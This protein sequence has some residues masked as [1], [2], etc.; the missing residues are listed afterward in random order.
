MSQTSQQATPQTQLET[1]ERERTQ[2]LQKITELQQEARE[3]QLVLEAFE[4]VEQSRRCFRLVGGVLVEQTVAEV[5]PAV[6]SNCT[7]IE[8]FVNQLNTSLQTKNADIQK[9]SASLGLS[10]SKRPSALARASPAA[11]AG[12]SAGVLV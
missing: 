9:I 5:Q 11:T 8:E 12:A 1:L 4:K 6:A 2:L 7:K 10:N 3:H